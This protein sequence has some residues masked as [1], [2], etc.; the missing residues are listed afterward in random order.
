MV[1]HSSTRALLYQ[2]VYG[3]SPSNLR[4]YMFGITNI[5]DVEETLMERAKVL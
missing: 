2:V 4:D 5:Q 3:R 1:I